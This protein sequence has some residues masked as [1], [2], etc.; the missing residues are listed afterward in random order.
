MDMETITD[1]GLTLPPSIMIWTVRTFSDGSITV[2]VLCPSVKP[3][4]I[5]AA[6]SQALSALMD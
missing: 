3:S 2:E 5:V 1:G 4:Q 6:I